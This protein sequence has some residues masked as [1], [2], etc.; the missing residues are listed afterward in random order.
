MLKLS[1]IVP[2]YKA[3]KYVQKCLDSILNQS[4]KDFEIIAIND[5]SPD[6]TLSILKEY[7]AIDNR[8][9]IINHTNNLGVAEARNSGLKVS[10]GDYIAFVDQD[11]WVHK[12]MY[13]NLIN[14]ALTNNADIVECNYE[15]NGFS[16]LK[17]MPNKFPSDT[18]NISDYIILLYRNS[19]SLAL[20]NKIYNSKSIKNNN[21]FFTDHKKVEAE[22]L[23]FNLEVFGEKK[24]INIINK[25][26]YYHTR[27]SES[28]SFHKIENYLPKT[29]NLINK[30]TSTIKNSIN[31][32]IIL[33]SF[34]LLILIKIRGIL[35]QALI[36]DKNHIHSAITEL[37]RASKNR[38]IN[39]A[40]INGI[41]NKNTK[42]IDRA[43]A[44]FFYL[45]L[46][47]ILSFIYYL[48][49]KIR[50]DIRLN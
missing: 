43:I 47:S 5:A 34:S 41:L 25:N 22:D 49:V 37:Q 40:A 36:K 39:K 15:E 6:N 44:L 2:F 19:L 23:L 17:N 50:K 35:F 48:T 13:E 45:K 10:K 7:Q 42:L 32:E 46:Y 38:I 31:Y 30:Y 12:D 26:Y 1:I 9:K 33:N 27:H 3:E 11:D 28:L 4:F 8:I 20:W 14:S 18:L 16:V 24:I 29:D 21:I